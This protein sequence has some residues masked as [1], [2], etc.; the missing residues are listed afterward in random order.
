MKPGWMLVCAV[1]LSAATV[2]CQVKRAPAQPA[3]REAGEPTALSVYIPC[4]MVLPFQA[5]I[6]QFQKVQAIKVKPK[7]DNSNVLVRLISDKGHRPDV[8]ISPGVQEVRFL[9]DRGLIDS[10]S[11]RYFGS[12]TI[13]LLVPK[14]NPARVRSLAD[15]AK[16]AVK[17]IAL[18]DPQINS[19][20]YYAK[21][22]LANL[23]LYERVK[24]KLVPTEHPVDA[25][26]MVSQGQVEAAISYRTCP[27]ES[28]PE[29]L[30]AS[31]VEIVAEFPRESYEPAAVTAAI[32]KGA[33][34]H[35]EAEKFLQFL[36]QEETQKTLAQNGL[37]NE[38]GIDYASFKPSLAGPGSRAD[39][40]PG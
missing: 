13:V 28:N 3:N 35:A 7:Y 39:K 11:K 14:G 25:Y 26:K 33:A 9:E 10:A 36:L 5:V 2:G 4:G 21:Q 18:G 19:I 34:H 23:G 29:K 40:G 31:R 27:L 12:Y 20:G 15:L 24:H 16:P 38:R 30:Q 22:S 6:E 1:T 37:P 8:I 32:L 17:A